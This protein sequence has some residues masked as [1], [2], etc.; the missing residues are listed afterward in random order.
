MKKVLNRIAALVAAS[1]ISV[2]AVNSANAGGDIYAPRKHV[3]SDYQPAL[4]KGFYVGGHLGGTFGEIKDDFESADVDGV[5]GGIHLGYNYQSGKVV[6]GIEGDISLSGAEIE[7]YD[8][9]QDY[10]AS[11]RGRIGYA[12]SNTLI[13]ATAGVAWTQFSFDGDDDTETGYVVGLGA[14]HKLSDKWSLRGEV[15]HYGFEEDDVELDSTV[16]RAGLTFHI[17]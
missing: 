9:E 12:M 7:G 17:N 3:E 16:V 11:I 15:L 4:W 2:V 6:F 5:V 8:S 13:Y 10:L 1:V 14:D